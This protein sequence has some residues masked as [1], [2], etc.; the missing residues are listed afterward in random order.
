MNGNIKYNNLIYADDTV[1]QI[2]MKLLNASYI[3]WLP[4]IKYM[5]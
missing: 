3:E 4:L 2:L 5:E 1:L